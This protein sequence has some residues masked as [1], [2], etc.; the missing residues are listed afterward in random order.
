MTGL[1]AIDLFAGAG[2][3][4][5]AALAA[6]LTVAWAGNHSPLAVEWHAR[7]HPTVEHVCQDLRQADFRALPDV[8]VMLA[9]PACQ[10]HSPASQSKRRP[11]HDADRSTAWAVIDCA[12]AKRPLVVVVENVPRMRAWVLYPAWRAALE[13]LGYTL[14]ELVLDA[15]DHGVPQNRQ[16]LFVVGRLDGTRVEP[17]ARRPRRP[18]RGIL[19][20]QRVGWARIDSK[21]V[22][23]QDRVANGRRNG[24]GVTFLSQH[25]TDHPGRSLDRPIGTVTCASQHWHLVDGDWMRALTP[26]ELARCQGIRDD[27]ELP[28]AAGPATRLIGNAVPP[29]LAAEVIRAATA[30]CSRQLALGVA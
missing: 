6:G 17:P 27:F 1:R 20:P 22:D 9:G 4:T 2:G 8:E 14:S 21:P 23:V 15:A 7:N 3:F 10:G 24:L 13:A 18:V 16:R 25:V 19:G 5:E 12:E 30:G 26:R 29:P 11:K 28:R